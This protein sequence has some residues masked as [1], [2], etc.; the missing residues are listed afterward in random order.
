VGILNAFENT[1]QAPLPTIPQIQQFG[2][3]GIA[4]R[5]S[6]QDPFAVGIF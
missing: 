2:D 6:S 4:L 1:Q 3:G 5:Q